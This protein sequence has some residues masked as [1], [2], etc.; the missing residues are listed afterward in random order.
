MILRKCHLQCI[1]ETARKINECNL[2]NTGLNK[3]S[4]YGHC[5]NLCYHLNHGGC[6]GANYQV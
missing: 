4:K 1:G 5:K 3:H 2:H 6:K